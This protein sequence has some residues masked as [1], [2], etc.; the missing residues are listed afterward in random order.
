MEENSHIGVVCQIA[1]NSTIVIYDERGLIF[2]FDRIENIMDFKIGDVVIFNTFLFSGHINAEMPDKYVYHVTNPMF[3]VL[4]TS[5]AGYSYYGPYYLI[6]GKYCKSHSQNGKKDWVDSPFMTTKKET[7]LIKKIFNKQTVESVDHQLVMKLYSDIET[8]IKRLDI[9]KIYS[10]LKIEI[11]ESHQKKLGDDDSYYVW[12]STS[13]KTEDPYIESL[14]SIGNELLYSETAFSSWQQLKEESGYK[15]SDF[16][17]QDEEIKKAIE[18]ATKL[19]SYSNHHSILLALK[20]QEIEYQRQNNLELELQI[21]Q[22][23]PTQ[24]YNKILSHQ[25]V[26]LVDFSMQFDNLMPHCKNKKVFPKYDLD[27]Y[28]E[29]ISR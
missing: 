3:R 18:R 15:D 9:P 29:L 4:K 26:E 22:N 24:R 19:Y 10:S 13:I 23:W 20:L 8:Y 6:Y 12:K 2:L 21:M 25:N 7:L 14:F 1:S 17:V 5:E 27:K 16:G 28:K 11:Y